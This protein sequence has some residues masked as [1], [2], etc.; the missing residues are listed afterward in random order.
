VL[1]KLW[2]K[3]L[4]NLNSIALVADLRKF[5][6]FGKQGV[7]GRPEQLDP[8]AG[9][10]ESLPKEEAFQTLPMLRACSRWTDILEV[11]TELA[12]ERSLTC[13]VG[14]DAECTRTK[15]GSSGRR[16]VQD[17]LGVDTDLKSLRFAKT[18]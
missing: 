5:E 18:E 14:A 2:L 12:L 1:S 3:C 16:M 4:Q 11:E 10:F 6:K 13:F 15:R 8:L 7:S 17:I 9:R